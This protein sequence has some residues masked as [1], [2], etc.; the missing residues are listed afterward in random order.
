MIVV[1]RK[2]NILLIVLIFLLSIAVYSLN[3]GQK[4]EASVTLGPTMQRTVIVDAG[5]GGEHPGA[6]SDYSGIKEKDINLNIAKKLQELLE[7]DNYKVIMTRS[8]D[9]LNYQ[10]DTNSIFLKRKEDLL[11][12]KK[13]MDNSG[14]DIIVSI[15]LNKFDQTQYWGAQTFYPPDSPESQKLAGVLQNA[16]K[17]FVDPNNNRQ[18]QLNNKG[19][20]IFRNVK[21]PIAIIEC[22]FL[23]NAE[24]EKKLATEEYQNKI[25]EAIKIGIDRYFT[26]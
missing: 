11:N 23:S 9:I 20:I 21:T 26:S 12:R 14:A 13:I 8:E 19:I 22:G 15:H 18:P 5:H 3:I 1:V 16:L 17:E 6:V 24:E 25:A 7:K 10:S 4:D 2:T